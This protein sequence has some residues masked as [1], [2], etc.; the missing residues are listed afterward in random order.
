[1]AYKDKNMQKNFQNVWVQDRRWSFIVF[2]GGICAICGSTENLEVD[3][4]DRSLKTMNPAKLWSLSDSNP[5]KIEE[6]KN[7]QVLCYTCHKE[8]TRRE[9]SKE[10]QH[11][12]Y[13]MYSKRGCRCRPCKDA[14]AENKRAWREKKKLELDK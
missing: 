9:L 12:E 6:L 4:I 14:N 13:G 5:K 8:K 10:Y 3:H 7:C 2:M 11:G 1:M